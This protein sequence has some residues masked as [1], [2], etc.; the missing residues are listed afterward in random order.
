MPNLECSRKPRWVVKSSFQIQPE[1]NLESDQFIS[2]FSSKHVEGLCHL[3]SKSGYTDRYNVRYYYS[4]GTTCVNQNQNVGN[5][6]AVVISSKS[7][8]VWLLNSLVRRWKKDWGLIDNFQ[9]T[10]GKLVLNEFL[11]IC[12]HQLLFW[13]FKLYD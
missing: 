11:C 7:H 9:S 1:R 3:S 13:K 8:M 5:L 2:A 10:C 4:L 6:W 12:S